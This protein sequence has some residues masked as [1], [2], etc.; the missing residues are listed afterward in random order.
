MA[1]LPETI[2]LR[3]LELKIHDKSRNRTTSELEDAIVE[4]KRDLYLKDENDE[5]AKVYATIRPN[6]GSHEH[7]VLL[8]IE[9]FGTEVEGFIEYVTSAD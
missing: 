3:K 5:E 6:G 4:V 8:Y 9:H 2:E 1:D 7:N